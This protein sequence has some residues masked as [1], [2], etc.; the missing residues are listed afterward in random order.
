[1]CREN[2]LGEIFL[3][4][5]QF[6]VDDPRE[7]GIDAAVEF[8]PHKLARNLPTVNDRLDIVN[9]HYSGHAMEY[10]ALAARGESWP[11]PAY[12]LFK[13]VSPRWDNEARKPGRGYS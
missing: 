13:G 2:G 10:E 8:P 7:F 4:M 3:A 12:P 1:F 6:D 5:V 11:V 9:P